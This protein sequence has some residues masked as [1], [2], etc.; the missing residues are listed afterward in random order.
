[1]KHKTL[2]YI[3][4]VACC[5]LFLCSCTAK[6]SETGTKIDIRTTKI[7][8]TETE[9]TVHSTLLAAGSTSAVQP[10]IKKRAA[11][12]EIVSMFNRA[13]NQ[14]KVEKP[15]YK[16]TMKPK[17]DENKIIISENIPFRS[18]ITKF[19]ASAINKSS[20]D[21]IEVKKD[22]DH[23]DF[24]V[25]GFAWASKLEPEALAGATST[26]KGNYYEL[27]LRF[28]EEKLPALPEN[29][30]TTE[31]GKAFS[32]L[33]SQDFKKSFGGFN[34]KLPGLSVDVSN[35][36]FAPTYTGSYIR[37]KIDK[38]ALSMLS[39]TYYLNTVSEVDMAVKVNKQ[40]YKIGLKMEYSVTEEYIIY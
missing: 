5:F 6:K 13:A 7:S 37:C 27:E 11:I 23:N 39:A 15:G 17:I 18:F 1:M 32:L 22:T 26:D 16:F 21:T 2:L 8:V 30:E 31:H 20:Q 36:K 35:E 34:V 4:G 24:P 12:S 29:P 10:T 14:V 9:T 28:K 25:K 19:I 3:C 38:A 33:T 40:I